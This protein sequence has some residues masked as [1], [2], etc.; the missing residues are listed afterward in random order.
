M[1]II[2]MPQKAASIVTQVRAGT[3]S[4]RNSRPSSAAENGVMLAIT[5][6]FATVVR[7]SARMKQ[8]YMS[9]HSAPAMKPDRPT[10]RMRRNISPRYWTAST[11]RMNTVMNS[12][13]QK[14][15]SQPSC[16]SRLRT[17]M[18]AVDQHSVAPI[19]SSTPRR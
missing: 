18:P 13:R 8:V 16:R 19:M 15:I 3:C 4:P 6:T 7:P 10:A 2:T 5:S 11:P 9:A 1:N 12:D 14:V 17:I